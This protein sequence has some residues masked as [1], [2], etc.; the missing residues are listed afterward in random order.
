MR[1]AGPD[2]ALR[3]VEARDGFIYRTKEQADIE[4]ENM[5]HAYDTAL[6]IY[7]TAQRNWL[8]PTEAAITANGARVIPT[9]P[10]LGEAF[11]ASAAWHTVRALHHLGP[12][13]PR[14]LLPVWGLNHQ[15]GSLEL[16]NRK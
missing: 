11:T 16:A 9:A 4:A 13:T 6:P 2:D 5:L 10:Y 15:L 7:R 12:G 8:G 1:A 14:L 3:L